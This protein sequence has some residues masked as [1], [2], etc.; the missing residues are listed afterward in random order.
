MHRD[1]FCALIYTHDPFKHRSCGQLLA[2]PIIFMF[3]NIAMAIIAFFMN[4]IVLTE[5]TSAMGY[6]FIPAPS[7][8]TAGG[9]TTDY[10]DHQQFFKV[11]G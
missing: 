4:H 7:G 1:S 11:S 3:I 2:A 9:K 5:R 10:Q 8:E 6:V